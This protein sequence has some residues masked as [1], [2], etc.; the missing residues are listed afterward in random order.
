LSD[1]DAG[2]NLVRVDASRIAAAGACGWPNRLIQQVRKEDASDLEPLGIQVGQIVSHNIEHALVGN[3]SGNSGEQ[4]VGHGF[5]S[6]ER[7]VG[8]AGRATGFVANRGY[9][10]Y[11][12]TRWDSLLRDILVSTFSFLAVTRK[13]PKM[14]F[15]IISKA[16]KDHHTP[17]QYIPAHRDAL[18]IRH[19]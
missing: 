14:M 4:C 5:V 3:Q 2:A 18:G 17:K 16:V 6:L 11:G 1:F 12:P 15:H 13:V 7:W 19:A 9:L 8:L 10:K